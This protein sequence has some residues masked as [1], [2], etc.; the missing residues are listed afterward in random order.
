MKIVLS[1]V[2]GSAQYFPGGGKKI[3]VEARDRDTIED[4]LARLGVSKDLFMFAQA[5]G[6]KV[7]LSYRVREGDDIMLV[8]PL[9]GG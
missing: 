8:S 3:E 9:A 6:E 4:M 5:N 1:C 2:G 7:D